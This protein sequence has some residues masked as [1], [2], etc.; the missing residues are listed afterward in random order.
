[1]G[2]GNADRGMMN[3]LRIAAPR[4]APGY[5][6]TI[7]VGL[8]DGRQAPASARDELNMDGVVWHRD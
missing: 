3:L 7:G 2:V 5:I 6:G 1:L 8:T 4:R